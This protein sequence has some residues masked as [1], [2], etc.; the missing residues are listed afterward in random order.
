MA[1]H[2]SDASYLQAA[3]GEEPVSA[4]SLSDKEKSRVMV[5]IRGRLRQLD[6][7]ASEVQIIHQQDRSKP[8]QL[9]ADEADEYKTL[10]GLYHSMTGR[11]W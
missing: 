10:Q 8:D 6:E 5:L 2:S 3:G 9:S 11:F 1:V 4:F 7:K